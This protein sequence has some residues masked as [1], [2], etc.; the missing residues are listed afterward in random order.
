MGHVYTYEEI[1]QEF[2]EKEYI[3]LT[4]RKLKCDE[5]YEYICKRH[6]DKG[7]QFID[8]RHFHYSKRGCYYCGRERTEVAR[9][10]DL[11]E[12][13]GRVLAES[14]GFEYVGMS[15]HD[16]KIW[17]QFICPKH[18]QYGVQEMPYNNMK[19]V[20]VGC[21]H[22]IGRDDDEEEVLRE[23]HKVNPFLELLEPYRGRTKRI[24]MLCTLHNVVS[25]K[26]PYEAIIGKGCVQCGLEKL[27]QQTKLPEDVFVSR[28]KCKFPHIVLKNGYD[29]ITN[30]AKFHCENCNS[31]F[32][33]YANYVERRGC[34]VCDSTSMEQQ[35]AQVFTNHN[36]IYKPQFS[37]DDCK[38]RRKL[39]FDFYLPDYNIL[40]EYDG[41]QHY[42]PVNFG[43][44]S[45]EKAFE[46]FKTTQR[47]DSIKTAYCE[48]NKIPLLRIPYW[49][50][51]NI[52]QILLDY[53][54]GI[55][56]KQND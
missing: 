37:F 19:R 56:T 43:G 13:D 23:I 12:Y 28:L 11:S 10:K 9:R 3:L 53:I 26:T 27:S 52:E 14:K 48:F 5:K 41:Q 34:P 16:K 29:G 50:S 30:L 1:K 8:W 32:I 6:I 17:I 18:R 25:R 39:P 36:I 47:H 22:C 45:D 31:D 4:N 15:K 24:Q 38:D 44:I 35:I 51:K 55:I 7:S 40:V 42:R 20:V 21:R 33:D 2:E 46:N 49:E 54:K